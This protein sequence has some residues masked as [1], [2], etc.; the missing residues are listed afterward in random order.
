M[1]LSLNKEAATDK[2]WL[3]NQSCSVNIFSS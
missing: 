2:N 3:V 1:N